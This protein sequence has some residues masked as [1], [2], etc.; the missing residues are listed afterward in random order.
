MNKITAVIGT[1]MGV[2]V[3]KEGCADLGKAKKNN[4]NFLPTE[5]FENV[6]AMFA[7]L[8]DTG[9]DT[10]PGWVDGEFKFFPCVGKGY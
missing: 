8:L 5:V 9:D 1:K 10:N 6:N 4:Y 3:H 7:A 2:D